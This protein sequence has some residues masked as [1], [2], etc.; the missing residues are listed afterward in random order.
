M[1]LMYVRVDAMFV[2]LLCFLSPGY[3]CC[4]IL[5][6]LVVFLFVFS[7]IDTIAEDDEQPGE[8]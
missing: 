6:P 4:M 5:T 1:I 8:E 7:L 2:C 3:L